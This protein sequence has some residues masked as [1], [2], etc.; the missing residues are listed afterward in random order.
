MPLQVVNWILRDVYINGDEFTM[1]GKKMRL[2]LVESP[3]KKTS[4]EKEETAKISKKNN[5]VNSDSNVISL[6]DLKKR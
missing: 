1:N 4:E 3:E 6:Q 5:S 2:E